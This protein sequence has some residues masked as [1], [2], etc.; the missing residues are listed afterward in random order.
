MHWIILLDVGPPGSI[1][2][3]NGRLLLRDASLG[4]Q[5]VTDAPA[6]ASAQIRSCTGAWHARVH[7][8]GALMLSPVVA[9]EYITLAYD[10]LHEAWGPA[11][12]EARRSVYALALSTRSRVVAL[13]LIL[14]GYTLSMQVAVHPTTREALYLDAVAVS[15]TRPI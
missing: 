14:P 12:G 7:K 6:P 2:A 15:L 3:C 5:D 1:A 13:N 4:W 9:V 8:G 10:R 11:S